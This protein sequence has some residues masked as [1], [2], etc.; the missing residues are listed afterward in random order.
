MSA[1]EIAQPVVPAA[2]AEIDDP[3]LSLKR[4]ATEVYLIRHA[5]ALPGADEVVGG[6]YDEQAL[7]ELGR[8]Q[9]QAL[10]ERM[11]GT[12]LAAVYSSPIGRAVQTARYVADA[13]GLEV[14]IEP[15]VREVMLG[16]IG[17]NG[18]EQTSP[19]EVAELLRQRLREIAVIAV[20]SGKW[21]S[22]PG[23]EASEALR[24]R[25]SEA[26]E[27]LAQE[28]AGERIAIVSHGGSINAYIA[29][30]LGIERDYFFPAV[31][32]SISVVRVKGPARMVFAL[33]D[34]SH[35]REA[36][37]FTADAGG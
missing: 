5:D 35:L 22:I 20:T 27:R 33:N 10:G 7:S 34:I 13:Q 31:N 29:T 15:G 26:V 2:G 4:G 30:I 24:A 14:R 16:P 1:E 11:K 25:V 18:D 32:T 28:H 37:L 6:G 23:A 21:A 17:V 8:R 19:E 9:G 3:F 12:P 36:G